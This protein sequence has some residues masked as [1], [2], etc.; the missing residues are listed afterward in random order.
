[1]T[2]RDPEKSD[3]VVWERNKAYLEERMGRGDYEPGRVRKAI[4]ME[5][6]DGLIKGVDSPAAAV[7]AMLRDEKDIMSP[8]KW[9]KFAEKAAHKEE[10]L[11][12]QTDITQIPQRAK[13]RSARCIR[14]STRSSTSSQCPT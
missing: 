2:S 8:W 10:I 5:I 3:F 9:T 6:K 4:D 1:V 13:R 7:K 14:H 12:L 11:K